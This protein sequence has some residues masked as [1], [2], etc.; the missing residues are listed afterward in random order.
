MPIPQISPYPMPTR[1]PVN[2][3]QWSI[4]RRRSML[5]IHDMQ[6]YFL[7][8]FPADQSPVK[9]LVENV[10]HLR[11]QC[12]EL[13]IPVGYTAQPGGMTGEQRGL[14]EDFWGAGHDHQPRA[15]RDR[16]PGWR[17]VEGDQIYTKWR[18][19]AFH[20]SDLLAFL[21]G[22][23]RDQLI[24]CGVY[25]HV[26]VRMTA[27]EAF[28]NDIE[29]FLVADAVA[30]FSPGLSPVGA[31]P[32][33]L[34]GARSPCRP[35]PPSPRCP[36]TRSRHDRLGRPG[37]GRRRHTGGYP[38]ARGRPGHRASVRPAPPTGHRA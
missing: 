7:D 16:G 37:V 11:D 4:D 26:G 5:L 35:I 9:E 17:P 32:T 12:A 29:A 31:G 21:R 8:M 2:V 25:A 23:G 22:Q 24:I 1:L 33:Q 20:R 19:S 38:G 28:T 18:Y 3:A 13:G 27:C 36:G 30:D 6:K 10:G 14:L 15:A 34:N